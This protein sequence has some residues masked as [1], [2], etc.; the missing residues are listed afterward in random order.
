MDTSFKSTKRW[1]KGSDPAGF[2]FQNWTVISRDE[3]SKVKARCRCGTVK[4]IF[5]S[6]LLR[7]K[8]HS[9]GCLAGKM[10]SESK[11]VHGHCKRSGDST[12]YRTWLAMKHRCTRP[13]HAQFK[14][15]GGRGISICERWIHSFSSFLSDMGLKPT[16]H[17][18]IER[19]NNDGNYEPDNCRWATRAEQALNR[20]IKAL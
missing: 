18:T 15:Y 11:I 2:Q 12:E 4:V 16:A 5:F 17:H 6:T 7:A 13:S 20:R 9:C 8:S 1:K 14:D 3:K 19:N 10:I